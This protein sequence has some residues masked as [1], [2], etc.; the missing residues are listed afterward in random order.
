MVSLHK[1]VII[2]FEGK[3]A[4]TEKKYFKGIN[5]NE[6]IKDE[7]FAITHLT[8]KSLRIKSDGDY[9][10]KLETILLSVTPGNSNFRVFII[11]DN[12]NE[13]INNIKKYRNKI[14][15]IIA[16]ILDIEEKNIFLIELPLNKTF[17]YYLKLHFPD[18]DVSKDDKI[19]IK[20]QLG[21]NYKQK[22]L[23]ILI[24]YY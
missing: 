1:Y 13:A 5:N 8:F 3:E 7:I 11:L 14:F 6:K 23:I 21:S 22:M 19:F 24:S 9:K 2:C 18:Y 16:D 10:K 17:E 12:D 20:E 4:N 15:S